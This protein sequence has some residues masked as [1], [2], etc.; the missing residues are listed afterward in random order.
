MAHFP[1]YFPYIM[2]A[3]LIDFIIQQPHLSLV[4]WSIIVSVVSVVLLYKISLND[5]S[6]LLKIQ[7]SQK[8]FFALSVS[9]LTVFNPFA[10]YYG[11]LALGYIN[12]LIAGVCI[13]YSI[14]KINKSRY[15]LFLSAFL[16]GLFIGMRL[17]IS[18][19][20]LP[21][22]YY[23]FRNKISLKLLVTSGLF[24]LAG[25]ASW[26]VPT[27]SFAGSFEIWIQRG[28]DTF[29]QSHT[30]GI[31]ATSGLVKYY[32]FNIFKVAGSLVFLAGIGVILFIISPFK[33]IRS[34]RSLSGTLKFL[35]VLWIIPG[36]VLFS[37]G[38][39]QPGYMMFTQP[40]LSILVI[41][42]LFYNHS[43]TVYTDKNSILSL[44]KPTITRLLISGILLVQILYFVLPLP[45]SFAG[46]RG[47]PYTA[48]R[49]RMNEKQ[50][51]TARSVVEDLNPDA[52]TAM[53]F[54]HE[55]PYAWR[56]S[57]VHFPGIKVY[58]VLKFEEGTG[59]VEGYRKHERDILKIGEKPSGSNLLDFPDSIERLFIFG[60]SN[61]NHFV[62]DFPDFVAETKIPLN[63]G[64]FI[65]AVR[66]P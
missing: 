57:M 43:G 27:A 4:T 40:V 10:W 18:L 22:I 36:A 54:Y 39:V 42:L 60:D 55:L 30:E 20:V 61:T 45:A 44:N 11:E 25:L 56:A 33:S 47:L 7:E 31:V 6:N 28:L 51:E 48:Q 5:I 58:Q 9:A 63:N 46:V 64:K 26:I 13:L 21:L 59:V 50:V 35:V 14:L 53:L 12:G 23:A 62:I 65:I 16:I 66:R 15:F 41:A 52:D 32:L 24:L 38:Y 1:G 29:S 2:G 8:N 3:K 34:W 49:I 37:L 17:E 19:L